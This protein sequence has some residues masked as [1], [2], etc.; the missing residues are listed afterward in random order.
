M[1]YNTQA[2]NPWRALSEALKL[3][4]KLIGTV[5]YKAEIDEALFKNKGFD[6][7]KWA[8]A[9]FVRQREASSPDEC[10]YKQYSVES[11]VYVLV[12]N[13][14]TRKLELAPAE[15]VSIDDKGITAEWPESEFLSTKKVFPHSEWMRNVFPS[16]AEAEAALE[17]K[18]RS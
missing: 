10:S 6:L 11:R 8:E 15:V 13:H 9:E 4:V 2:L 1:W 12:K 14:F 16:Q 3:V 18:R 5:T 7:R 17:A